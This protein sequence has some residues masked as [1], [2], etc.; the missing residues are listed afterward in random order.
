MGVKQSIIDWLESVPGPTEAQA[1]RWCR[2]RWGLVGLA[3][4]AE[5]LLWYVLYA[6]D[7]NHPPIWL[8]VPSAWLLVHVPAAQGHANFSYSLREEMPYAFTVVFFFSILVA[9][10]FALF[11]NNRLALRGVA[12]VLRVPLSRLFVPIFGEIFFLSIVAYYLFLFYS[13]PT[14]TAD[15]RLLSNIH[16]YA[17]SLLVFWVPMFGFLG[18]ILGQHLVFFRDLF[19]HAVRQSH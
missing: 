14:A 16:E 8:S 6:M 7:V 5:V 19:A 3:V 4:L 1:R 13:Q 18:M 2:I 9:S 15:K 17:P 11:N 10:F 12:N